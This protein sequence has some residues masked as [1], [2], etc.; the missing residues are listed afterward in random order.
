M[1]GAEVAWIVA[2]LAGAVALALLVRVGTEG[3]RTTEL[4]E[5]LDDLR[6]EAKTHRKHDEQRDKALRR[7]EADLDKATRK[8]AQADKRD[9]QSKGSA[10]QEREALLEK[11][12]EVEGELANS[13]ARVA[14]LEPTLAQS[15]EEFA[16]ATR[17][18]ASAEA[19]AEAAEA[20]V[21]A[22][23]PPAD[24][25]E[26]RTLRER[27]DSVQQK[28]AERDDALAKAN[29]EVARLKEKARTQEM[30]YTSVRSE[31]EVK[32]DQIRQQRADIERLQALEV[33]LST[34]D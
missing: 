16:V 7:A 12:S 2:G 25:E 26:L 18:V 15:R 14:E 17:H 29:A 23:P 30:L 6:K 27:A 20:A 28:L 22:A 4:R 9:A 31:L 34:D 21:A 8:R 10:R 19:R 13:T 3:R 24:P 1:A 11:L 33:A 5:Q 32:K